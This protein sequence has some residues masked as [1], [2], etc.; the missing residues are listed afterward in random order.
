MVQEARRP[1]RQA[2]LKDASDQVRLGYG[3][4]RE[5]GVLEP[6]RRESNHDPHSIYFS[7]SIL[8][9]TLSQQMHLRRFLMHGVACY[10]CSYAIQ[11]ASSS[12]TSSFSSWVEVFR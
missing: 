12:E 4:G 9:G 2:L 3:S 11:S 1:T 7:A 8:R 10:T 6:S 5:L